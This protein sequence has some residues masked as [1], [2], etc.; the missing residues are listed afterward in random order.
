QAE[1]G[2][3]A[4]HVTGV[5]TCAL[6]ICSPLQIEILREVGHR[7]MSPAP[8]AAEA[9]LCLASLAGHHRSNGNPGWLILK[10]GYEKLSHYE[11][12]W[13][14]EE[15]RVGNECRFQLTWTRE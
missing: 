9:L 5:Q 2:I 8:T 4:F 14:S 10:R 13:R 1:D 3:R 12:G 6:P 15:R 11:I 7:P